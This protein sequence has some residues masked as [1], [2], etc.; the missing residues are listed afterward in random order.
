[1]KKLMLALR[2]QP[3]PILKSRCEKLFKELKCLCY[4]KN[5]VIFIPKKHKRINDIKYSFLDVNENVHRLLRNA[6][7]Y[8][9][10]YISFKS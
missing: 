10:T 4:S 9:G 3:F 2:L 1:M 8:K 7:D 5:S 6:K